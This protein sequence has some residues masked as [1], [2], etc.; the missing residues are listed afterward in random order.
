MLRTQSI[1]SFGDVAGDRVY[2]EPIS[3]T[4]NDAAGPVSAQVD[5]RAD[6]YCY[7]VTNFGGETQLFQWLLSGSAADYEIYATTDSGTVTGTVG[8]W[9]GMNATN[10]WSKTR[11][12]AG[13]ATWFGNFKIRDAATLAELA[14]QDPNDTQIT[15]DIS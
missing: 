6:G 13:S 1:L 8:S 2:L 11:A 9:V 10:T 5:F 4:D 7:S 15:V 3:V 14:V 12:V